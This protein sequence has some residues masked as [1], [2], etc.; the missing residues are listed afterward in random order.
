MITD[1]KIRR[2]LLEQIANWEKALSVAKTKVDRLE[3]GIKKLKKEL[4]SHGE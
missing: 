1:E 2:R 3:Q 4:K